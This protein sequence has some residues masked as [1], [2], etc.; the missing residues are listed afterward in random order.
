MTF[1]LFK[2]LN[3]AFLAVTAAVNILLLACT[4]RTMEAGIAAINPWVILALIPLDLALALGFRLAADRKYVSVALTL[5]RDLDVAGF[6]KAN[7]PLLKRLEAHPEL[8]RTTVGC[9]I[10][11]NEACA[12]AEA[13]DVQRAAEGLE[14]VLSDPSVRSRKR[15]YG[16]ALLQMARLL[17]CLGEREGADKRVEELG[18]LR[19]GLTEKDGSA[20]RQ[21]IGQ[22]ALRAGAARAAYEGRAEDAR[23]LLAQAG[24][25]EEQRLEKV[26]LACLAAFVECLAGGGESGKAALDGLGQEAQGLYACAETRRRCGWEDGGDI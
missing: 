4:L 22:F 21:A 17:Y 5:S 7:A 19:D 3:S 25:G 14:A 11:M 9:A 10:R 1:K 16:K 8:N 6:R 12:L 23:R 15:I 13:G 18:R 24:D 2:S 20:A 26:R